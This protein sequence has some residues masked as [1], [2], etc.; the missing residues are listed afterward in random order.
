CAW[1]GVALLNV[2]LHCCVSRA[3]IPATTGEAMDVPLSLTYPLF[4]AVDSVL[5]PLA[6]M[7][8]FTRPSRV[9]P[10]ELKPTTL[11]PESVAPTATT[12]F[13]LAVRPIEP[14]LARTGCGVI[15]QWP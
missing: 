7:S 3:A 2:C 9:G 10:R 1:M 12:F 8:G 14:T 5:K 13:E 6:V 11:R 15:S 4:S